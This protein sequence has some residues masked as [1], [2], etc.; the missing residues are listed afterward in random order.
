VTKLNSKTDFISVQQLSWRVPNRQHYKSQQDTSGQHKAEHSNSLTILDELNFSVKVG[1]FVGVIG[2]NGAGKSSLLRCLYGKITPSS[3][4]ISLNQRDL[5]S[6]S[7]RQLANHIAVVLQ[8]PPTQ[9]E[10]S[11]MDVIRMGLIPQKQLLSFDNQQDEAAI[12]DAARQV[13]LAAKLHHEFNS[14]SGGEK[15]RVMI[16]RA[17]LQKPQLLLMDEPTNHLDV[18]H[19]IDVLQLAASLGITVIVSIHDLNLAATYCDRLILM[20]KG[21]IAAQ[22]KPE[23]VLTEQSLK[24]VFA[25]DAAIDTHPYSQKTR[26]TFDLTERH[27]PVEVNYD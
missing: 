26:I 23:Q 1:E 7:K 4:H 25:V 2:P 21:K 27:N 13:D 22:G 17:I 8:E 6:Y 3:G 19:Q 24:Q 14:L 20:D 16:A 10:L 12:T 9:F 18:R 15:Q 5:T 11:V